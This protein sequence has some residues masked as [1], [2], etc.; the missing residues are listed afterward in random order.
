M[1]KLCPKFPWSADTDGNMD[2]NFL[3]CTHTSYE[4]GAWWVVD[5]G[6]AYIISEIMIT[7]GQSEEGIKIY[8]STYKC[9]YFI[10]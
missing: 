7:I 8:S 1:A 9:T 10:E 2:T 6:S 5:L 3:D 4:Q